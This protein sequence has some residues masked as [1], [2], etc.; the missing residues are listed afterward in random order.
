M[1]SRR[2]RILPILAVL[3]YLTAFFLPTLYLTGQA[4]TAGEKT[5]MVGLAAFF[6]GFFSLFDR[7]YAWLANPM[8]LVALILL[9]VRAEI[10]ALFF[11]LA[12]LL[13]AQ[14]TWVLVGT[15]IWGDEGGVTKYLVTSLGAG[16][17]LWNFSF[18][19]LA[20]ASLAGR[21]RPAA[22]PDTMA[23]G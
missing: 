14:Q 13:I 17:Y 22:A 5:S 23:A 12:A 19:L 10:P 1:T 20:V 18:I 3:C 4:N 9:L 8:A 11:S 6:D 15:P 2:L 7:Q 16:F 21:F